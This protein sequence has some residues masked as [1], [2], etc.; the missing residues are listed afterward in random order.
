MARGA[1][2]RYS[3]TG[4][5]HVTFRPKLDSARVL[6]WTRA[7]LAA[8]AL[9]LGLLRLP[10]TGPFP[11]AMG[12]YLAY[13]AVVAVRRAP[14]KGLPGL[15]ALIGDTIFFLAL[16]SFAAESLPWLATVFLLFLLTEALV[17]R[18]AGGS[19][20]S[21]RH[22]RDFLR[23]GAA[24]FRAPGSGTHGGGGRSPGVRPGGPQP[25]PGGGTAP[26]GGG[27]GRRAR[28][29]PEG[30]RPGAGAHRQRF[31]RRAVAKF[32]QPADAPGDPPQTPGTRFR[33]RHAG[34]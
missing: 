25:P 34:P 33:C 3:C 7:L 10:R 19:G 4:S 6:A 29:C 1:A 14:W 32:H 2:T 24:G 13:A 21:E 23:R 27:T 15:L 8:A 9:S 16:A 26:A 31:S 11:W 30:Y 22:G 20:H 5:S 12:A 28:G 17:F 18:D